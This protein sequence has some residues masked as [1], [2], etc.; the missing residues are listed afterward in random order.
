MGRE[1]TINYGVT[2]LKFRNDTSH[3]VLIRTAYSD[4]SITVSFYGDNE[5]RT[6]REED[7]KVLAEEPITDEVIPCPADPDV[8]KNNDCASL[9][10]FETK[11]IEDGHTGY[12]VQFTQVIDQPGKP[13]VRREYRFRYR[14]FKNKILIGTQVPAPP[15]PPPPPP[16]TP[17]TAAPPPTV[18]PA[19]PA[20]TAPPPP[21]G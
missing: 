9:T 10:L 21:P 8:D 16:T 14:M 13:Q 5:G 11:K 3:G 17:T 7:R 1:A 19:G 15:P 6:V 18:A 4:T 20:T 12:T 2:D